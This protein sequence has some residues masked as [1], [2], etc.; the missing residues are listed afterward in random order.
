ML[1]KIFK[2]SKKRETDIILELAQNLPRFKHY[3]FNF[4]KYR[5]EVP[6]FLSVAWQIKEY[7]EDNELDFISQVDNPIIIDCG[8][9]IGISILY[10]FEKYPLAKIYAFEPDPNI[11]KYL[12][13]NL[14]KNCINKELF[15]NDSAIWI[16]ELGIDFGIEGADGGSIFL[17]KK[18][19]NVKTTRLRD[20]IL[21][22]NRIDLLKI[23]IE[24]AEVEVLDDCKDVLENIKYI[25]C[26][27][28]S[29]K[30]RP[31]ELGKILK[32]LEN[33]DF[34]YNIKMINNVNG[35]AQNSITNNGMDL[36]LNIY[37][38]NNK[39]NI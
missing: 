3:T 20:F 18:S 21:K 33:A 23:D 12:K 5:I 24:G 10:F 14:T 39:K 19:I 36:Q 6:D 9:N 25:S 8:S 22:F 30:N 13:T 28:H 11:F 15:L 38:T 37:A 27:Y 35:F 16:N 1:Q 4:R 17:S 26:E 34:R 31:Q 2:K 7:F 32:I 29:F